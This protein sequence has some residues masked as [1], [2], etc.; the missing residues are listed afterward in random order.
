MARG[1]NQRRQSDPALHGEDGPAKVETAELSEG[2]RL[3]MH[4]D[5]VLDQRRYRSVIMV[6]TYQASRSVAVVN[7]Q[8]KG[9]YMSIAMSREVIVST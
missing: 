1:R 4:G 7:Y 8:M 6:G 3:V 2:A 9:R 5:A